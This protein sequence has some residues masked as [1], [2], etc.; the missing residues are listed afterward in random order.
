MQD[1]K[2]GGYKYLGVLEADQTK[3]DEIRT[4]SGRNISGESNEYTQVRVKR[5]Q[6]DQCHQQIGSI[7]GV[8]RRTDELEAMDRRTRKL[9]TIKQ[10]TSKNCVDRLYVS[11]KGGD[12]ELANIQDSV[13]VK[14]QSLTRHA[15]TSEQELLKS[16]NKENVLIHW[17]GKN[18]TQHEHRL[19][20]NHTIS[21]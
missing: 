16:T 5:R 12:R 13:N 20:Q 10:P 3:Q 11:R 7:A 9:I 8:K 17:N 21:G 18:D 1:I 6:C 2:D 19:R 4:N 15:D 14:E